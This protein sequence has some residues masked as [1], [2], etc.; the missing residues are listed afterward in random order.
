MPRTHT[1]I[2][3]GQS[4]EL[5]P[6]LTQ[7]R[8]HAL[9]GGL[10]AAMDAW[11]AV[12]ESPGATLVDLGTAASAVEAHHGAVLGQ[13]L[14]QGHPLR[15][16]WDALEYASAD[17]TALARFGADIM[18]AFAELD[19]SGADVVRAVEDA[20]SSVSRGP[21]DAEVAAARGN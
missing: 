20:L 11:R 21:T 10:W 15:A 4:Y 6:P 17:G 9:C 2:L 1:V 12:Q 7:A 18:E 19:V 13:M 16:R 3:G 14:P 8:R 5:R